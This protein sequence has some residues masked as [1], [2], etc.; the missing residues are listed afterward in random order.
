MLSYAQNAEDVILHRVLTEPSGFYLDVGACHPVIDSITYA[1][2]RR[3][4]RGINVEPDPSMHTRLEAVR[5]RDINLQGAVSQH[6]GEATFYRCPRHLPLSTM[7]PKVASELKESGV[8]IQQES[9][10]VTTLSHIFSEHAPEQ[11]DFLKVDVEGHEHEVLL[12][13][14][15]ERFR[16]I[17]VVVEATHPRTT[18]PVHQRWESVLTNSAYHFAHF[19]GLNRYYVREE[20]IELLEELDRPLSACAPHVP[21]RQYAQIRFFRDVM[22]RVASDEAAPLANSLNKLLHKM[23]EDPMLCRKSPAYLREL[24]D[25]LAE[26]GS[27]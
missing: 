4:W 24:M 6:S 12:G 2:Y 7:N 16:P 8:P 11:V 19:D 25:E 23:V 5:P 26:E 21:F 1:F 10:E 15:W 20:N 9:I 14:D 3:G 17:I 18:E 27:P 13:N 22:Q